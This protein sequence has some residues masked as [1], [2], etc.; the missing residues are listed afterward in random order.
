MEHSPLYA[1]NGES[2]SARVVCTVLAV[3][4]EVRRRVRVW[5][6]SAPWPVC[7]AW[8]S[9]SGFGGSGVKNGVKRGSEAISYQFVVAA[10]SAAA[11]PRD[12]WQ[13]RLGGLAARCH[14]TRLMGRAGRSGADRERKPEDIN[15]A[16]IVY[17]AP[18]AA[19]RTFAAAASRAI[20][21]LRH[22]RRHPLGRA[23]NNR[24]G[25]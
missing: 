19:R 12:T 2:L 8:A 15:N 10:A 9:G 7:R 17:G 13:A 5:A 3:R 24:A 25:D 11:L 16:P 18:R 23:I 22:S 14:V 4:W 6:A 1:A 20:I 21:C